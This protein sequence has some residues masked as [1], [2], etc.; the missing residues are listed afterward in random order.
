MKFL[1]LQTEVEKKNTQLVYLLGNLKDLGN[2]DTPYNGVPD[3]AEDEMP[4]SIFTKM[5]KKFRGKPIE[6]IKARDS[7]AKSVQS[8]KDRVNNLL[9]ATEL[10]PDSSPE[11]L[12]AKVQL[13]VTKAISDKTLAQQHKTTDWKGQYPRMS[14]PTDTGSTLKIFHPGYAATAL[15][16]DRMP[17][18]NFL[19]A[20]VPGITS[21]IS[22]PASLFSFLDG[23]NPA[24]RRNIE[25]SKQNLI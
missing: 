10:T 7:V 6:K 22:T 19:A 18:L 5:W 1:H 16:I 9:S 24:A 25:E 2:P 12:Q 21:V 15:G 13:D 4:P 23:S 3:I 11:Q 14:S 8:Y 20:N 17:P